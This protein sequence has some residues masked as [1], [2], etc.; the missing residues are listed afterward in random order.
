MTESEIKESVLLDS[1]LYKSR[2]L[3]TIL[4]NREACEVLLEKKDFTEDDIDN[5]IYK[6]VFPYLYVDETQTEVLTYI[7]LEVDI[8]RI[9]THTIKNIQITIWV[10]SH[11]DDMKY[12]KKG[13]FGTKVDILSDIV[14]RSLH[15]SDKF[16]I[17]KLSLYSVNHI[18]PNTKYY[19]KQLIFNTSDFKVKEIKR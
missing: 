18:F 9:P 14:E 12:S 16:G 1:G 17:G 7:C 13:Y 10:Y 3:S 15:N 19:G 11:K 6:Q 5:L 4:S 2:L 8:P